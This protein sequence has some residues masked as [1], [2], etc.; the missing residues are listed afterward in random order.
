[1]ESGL[2]LPEHISGEVISL[3]VESF[4][5]IF[6]PGLNAAGTLR[7]LKTNIAGLNMDPEWGSISHWTW[8]IF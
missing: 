7:P 3:Q 6:S 1:M 4:S 5:F 2:K 8:G